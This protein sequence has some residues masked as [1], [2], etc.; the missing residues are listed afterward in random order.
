MI[1]ALGGLY[2]AIA[3]IV[4]TLLVVIAGTFFE[5]ATSSH[6]FAARLTYQ[7]P[8]FRL[9][10]WLYFI[11]ILCAALSRYPFQTKH[12]P[13]LL[14]H[15]GLLLILLGVFVK[16]HVG[17]QGTVAL[18]EGSGTNKCL[19]PDTYALHIES[20][21][22]SSLVELKQ[23]RLGPLQ[24]KS[25]ALELTLL[26][27]TPHSEERLEGFI[28][29]DY[30]YLVGLPPFKVKEKGA[31]ESL[32][33]PEYA[34]YAYQECDK[35]A[36]TFPGTSSLFFITDS[37]KKEHLIAFNEKGERYDYDVN[38]DA[39]FVYNKGYGGYAFFAELPTHFP[40]LELIAPIT[41]SWKTLPLPK[42][43]EEA[44]P[45][46]R[47]LATSKKNS[48]IVTL[49]LDRY[50]QKFK[51]PILGGE[52]LIRFQSNQKELPI[53]MRLHAAKQINYPGTNQPY[54]YEAT[55]I[56]DDQEEVTLSMNHVFEKKGYRFYLANL[57]AASSGIHHVQ[58]VV[59]YDPA[60]YF[61]TYPG[62]ILLALGAALLYLRKRYV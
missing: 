11:N 28:K 58:I 24:L 50:G 32:K 45:R 40:E 47:L 60:K 38:G 21:K 36:I 5:S 18:A 13:F 37:A 27:W 4:C 33:T 54:S 34:I 9:L 6:A 17:V 16:N 10:L 22:S 48:E 25:D 56:F 26:E 14:T 49:N 35:D 20:P 3:L 62:A 46:I 39:Y 44:T 31:T 1:K 57:V 42:K 30:G 15:L 7:N 12:I 59:N 61:L 8:F 29:G 23:E 2:F 51:W 19:L 53:H 52:Y 55:M 41:R 43:R